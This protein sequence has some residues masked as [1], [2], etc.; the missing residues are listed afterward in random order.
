[1]DLAGATL[2]AVAE[3]AHHDNEESRRP[4]PG[5]ARIHRLALGLAARAQADDA[6]RL[7]QRATGPS[8][9]H[10]EDSVGLR[11]DEQR[12]A[13]GRGRSIRRRCWPHRGAYPAYTLQLSSAADEHVGFRVDGHPARVVRP[14][15][16]HIHRCSRAGQRIQPPEIFHHGESYEA[17]MEARRACRAELERMSGSADRGAAAKSMKTS[18]CL[19]P[20]PR[21]VSALRPRVVNHLVG[22]PDRHGP[23]HNHA[24]STGARF[25]L[26]DKEL[27]SGNSKAGGERDTRGCRAL[28]LA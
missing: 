13:T 11:D 19:V 6:G 22:D 8:R 26:R 24:G 2:V 23:A 21:R 25:P 7:A 5:R 27:D 1:M 20:D 17:L 10:V 14:G 15:E 9:D 3:A 12:R 16:H 28:G 18:A 4:C